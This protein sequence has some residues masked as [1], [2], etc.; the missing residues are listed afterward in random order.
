MNKIKQAKETRMSY[1]NI[2]NTNF[3]LINV[4]QIQDSTQSNFL[5]CYL[6]YIALENIRLHRYDSF[7]RLI[8]LF[9]AY[10][11]VNPGP[12]T[13]TNNS[14]PLNILPFHNCGEPTMPS[15]CNSSG[16][17]IVHDNFKLKIFKKKGFYFSTFEYQQPNN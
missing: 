6:S 16:C 2:K 15:K 8:L 4:L 11:N 3:F 7:F 5:R 1:N 10:I 9:S 13:V 14:I 17:Y 12:N